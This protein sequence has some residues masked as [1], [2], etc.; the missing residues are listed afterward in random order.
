MEKIIKPTFLCRQLRMQDLHLLHPA[1][2]GYLNNRMMRT[3]QFS[4]FKV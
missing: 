2:N 4:N 1:I 3:R